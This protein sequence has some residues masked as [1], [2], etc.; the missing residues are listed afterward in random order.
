MGQHARFARVPVLRNHRD[1]LH[2]GHHPA[3]VD[4]EEK[5]NEPWREI[6][7][8]ASSKLAVDAMTA[9]PGNAATLPAIQS[10]LAEIETRMASVEKILKEVG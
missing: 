1:R 10:E 7:G 8:V 5:R 2:L 4:M 9:Q 3:G 6:I